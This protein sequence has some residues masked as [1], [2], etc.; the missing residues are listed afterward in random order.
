LLVWQWLILAAGA[1]AAVIAFRWR[2]RFRLLFAGLL[3]LSL[4]AARAVT[5]QPSFGPQNAAE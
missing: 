5:A 2:S 3:V 4:G 1:L